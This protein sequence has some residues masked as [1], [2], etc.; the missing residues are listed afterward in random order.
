[1]TLGPITAT[2]EGDTGIMAAEPLHAV[3]GTGQVGRALVDQ[4]ADRGHRVDFVGN[5]D[6]PH[7]YS[8]VP[9]IAAG[10]ATLGSDRRAVGQVWHLP[11]PDTVETRTIVDLI[12]VEL[13]RRVGIRSVPKLMLR[14]A[15]LVSPMMREL[16]EMA[17]EFE[18]PFVL[19]TT[20]FVTTF[21]RDGTPLEAAVATTVA[22]YR[23]EYTPR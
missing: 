1:V 11:G 23:N 4:L 10:L 6:L 8:Y 7:T 17:Y 18:Q 3:F 15:S 2:R 22:W 19:D 9:D 13:G 5:P 16:A 14:A 20:R 21:G 12:G